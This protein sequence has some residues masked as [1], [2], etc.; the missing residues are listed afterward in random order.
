MEAGF[1]L[2]PLKAVLMNRQIGLGLAVA[3]FI[4]A[5]VVRLVL[6]PSAMRLLGDWNWWLPR[7]LRRL[8]G[9]DAPET[10][11]VPA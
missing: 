9:G 2:L 6:V 8:L 1:V 10:V 3:T 11:G 5:T 4:D 7:S